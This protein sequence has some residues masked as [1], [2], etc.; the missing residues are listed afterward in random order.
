MRVDEKKIIIKVKGVCSRYDDFATVV[1]RNL[2]DAVFFGK[3]FN[4]A[5]LPIFLVSNVDGEGIDLL[6]SFVN[7]ISENFSL[8]KVQQRKQKLPTEFNIINIYSYSKPFIVAGNLLF[9]V[10]QFSSHFL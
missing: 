5:V 8:K 4:E 7:T 9:F 2:E 3:T 10:Y 1:V 6:R